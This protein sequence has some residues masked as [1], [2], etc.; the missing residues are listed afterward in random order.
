MKYKG[1]RD[2]TSGFFSVNP[3]CLLPKRGQRSGYFTTF[4]FDDGDGVNGMAGDDF[5]L[6]DSRVVDIDAAL[7]DFAGGVAAIPPRSGGR[8]RCHPRRKLIANVVFNDATN[9]QATILK[10]KGEP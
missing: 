3:P 5:R 9:R 1:I 4:G 10:A 2:F 7:L 6:G 8:A